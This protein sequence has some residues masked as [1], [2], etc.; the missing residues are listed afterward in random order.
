MQSFLFG[1]QTSHC[2]VV[3][4]VHCNAQKVESNSCDFKLKHCAPRA[5]VSPGQRSNWNEWDS[6]F[7]PQSY[8]QC[9]EPDERKATEKNEG[10]QQTWE[11]LHLEKM[12]R[13]EKKGTWKTTWCGSF[14]SLTLPHKKHLCTQA[15]EDLH[16]ERVP[17]LKSLPLH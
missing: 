1:V 11:R 2:R 6:L 3:W 16:R 17:F 13:G 7:L 8:C 15:N 5:P 4:R 10:N 9:D 14:T 12:R